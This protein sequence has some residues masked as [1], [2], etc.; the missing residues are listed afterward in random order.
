VPFNYYPQS[1]VGLNYVGY[2]VGPSVTPATITS[3]GS[4]NVKGLYTEIVASTGFTCNRVFFRIVN[5]TSTAGR[6]YL[7]DMATGAGGAETVILPNMSAETAAGASFTAVGGEHFPIGIASGTRIA[8]RCQASGAIS[9][10]GRVGITLEAAG[11]VVGITNP[12]VNY[13]VDTST[14]NLTS[15]DPG[16]SANTKGSYTQLTAS[17]SAII[18]ALTLQVGHLGNTA[19]TAAFWLVDIATGAAASEVVLIPDSSA[20]NPGPI[21][22][23]IDQRWRMFLTYIAA[24]TRIAARASCSITDATDRLIGV[25]LTVAAE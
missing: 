14:S 21:N 8:V 25:G 18:Q 2:P 4:V 9:Q 15:I 22:G 10:T 16:G 1:A 7:F 19:P 6:L 12:W 24:S 20:S 5:T 13:G 11:D 3:A 17:T 23:E